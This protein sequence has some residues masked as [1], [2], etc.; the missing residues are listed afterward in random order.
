MVYTVA[1]DPLRDRYSVVHKALVTENDPVTG[2]YFTEDEGQEFLYI[3][4]SSS[5][6]SFYSSAETFALAEQLDDK[7]FISP[8]YLNLNLGTDSGCSTLSG[9]GSLVTADNM[10]HSSLLPAIFISGCL[11]LFS[12]ASRACS[13]L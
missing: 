1:G 11:F 2:L 7:G 5:V 10:V 12:D 13:W 3:T 9:D 6:Q 8:F 4:L